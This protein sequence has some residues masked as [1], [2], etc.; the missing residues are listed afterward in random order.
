MWGENIIQLSG[1]LSVRRPVL[2][3]VDFK[4]PFKLHKHA[5][6]LGLGAVLC[7]EQDGVEKVISYA[8]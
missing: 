8:S 6:I 2:A 5:S 3:Y 7:Q 4:K 1:I